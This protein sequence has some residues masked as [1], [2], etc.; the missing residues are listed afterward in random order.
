MVKFYR[1]ACA[2]AGCEALTSKHKNFSG[3][4][5]G[6]GIPNPCYV[7][8]REDRPAGDNKLCQK[9]YEA[10][11]ENMPISTTSAEAAPPVDAPD[12][13]RGDVGER[14]LRNLV[15]EGDS[16]GEKKK[17]RKDRQKD[18]TFPAVPTHLP[19]RTNRSRKK[20]ASTFLFAERDEDE[21]EKGVEDERKRPR[22]Q[23]A[24]DDIED[25]DAGDAVLLLLSLKKSNDAI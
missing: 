24:D 11:L 12:S 1:G 20:S 2:G 17:K 16:G 14:E 8:L 13:M 5:E 19:K 4:R 6:K 18:A 9:C 3:R 15:A 25:G 7:A 22:D 21:E 10:H 23:G